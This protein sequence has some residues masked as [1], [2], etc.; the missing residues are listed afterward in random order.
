MEAALMAT[1]EQMLDRIRRALALPEGERSEPSDLAAWPDLGRLMQPIP[2][3]ALIERFEEELVKV[4]SSPHRVRSAKEM[5]ALMVSSLKAE[6]SKGVV[7]SRNPLLAR[8]GVPQALEGAG[9]PFWIWPACLDSEPAA[10][11]D[12]NYREHCFSGAAG[13]TGVDYA[14]VESGSFVLTSFTEGSQLASLAP[15]VHFAIYLRSQVVET[16]EEVLAGLA[17][18]L[19]HSGEPG[20]MR[21][22]GRSVVFVTGTSR[23]ADIEQILIRGVHGPREVHAILVED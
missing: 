8:L 20:T 13:V 1:R 11:E 6:A 16:L 12:T 15:P 9:V 19:W 21:C 7:L 23:T 3:K 17:A 4:G 22:D 10:P 18:G 14:L 5:V 2:R